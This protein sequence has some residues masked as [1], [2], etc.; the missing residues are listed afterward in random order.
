MS[1]C[2]EH[3]SVSFAF[4]LLSKIRISFGK[5]NRSFISKYL[6]L[7]F[8]LFKYVYN[9]NFVKLCIKEKLKGN[10]LICLSEDKFLIF[11]EAVQ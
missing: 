2:A 1:V 11:N 9:K 7:F 6:L 4:C 3:H 8:S 10:R 5:S